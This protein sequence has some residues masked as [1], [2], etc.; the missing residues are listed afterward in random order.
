M[1]NRGYLSN[2]NF[3]ANISTFK[4]GA[5]TTGYIQELRMSDEDGAE[6]FM[7]MWKRSAEHNEN[8]LQ[9]II[10]QCGAAIFFDEKNGKYIATLICVKI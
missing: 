2:D 8:L 1:A 9:P 10:D 5:M 4:T 3:M 6:R 7:N